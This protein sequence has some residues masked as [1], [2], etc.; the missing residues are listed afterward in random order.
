MGLV[1]GWRSESDEQEDSTQRRPVNQSLK[2]N[3]ELV[4]LIH[5]FTSVFISNSS[6]PF[7]V[8]RTTSLEKT[9]YLT[10]QRVAAR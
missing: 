9:R 5:Y 7:S 8:F 3:L 2:S 6:P 1:T 4:K 10:R